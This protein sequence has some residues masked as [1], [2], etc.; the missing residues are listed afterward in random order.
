VKYRLCIHGFTFSESGKGEKPF[1]IKNYVDGQWVGG[2]QDTWKSNASGTYTL[3]NVTDY[4][5]HFR[6]ELFSRVEHTTKK[7]SDNSRLV[8]EV[9]TAGI[10]KLAVGDAETSYKTWD[11]VGE[12]TVLPPNP[13]VLPNLSPIHARAKRDLI[14]KAPY[15]FPN[16]YEKDKYVAANIDKE[17]EKFVE[18]EL[19]T[20]A[21]GN[22]TAPDGRNMLVCVKYKTFEIIGPKMMPDP[23]DPKYAGQTTTSSQ[24]PTYTLPSYTQQQPAWMGTKSISTVVQKKDG[25]LQPFSSNNL[26]SSMIKAGATQ[27]QATIVSNQIVNRIADKPTITTTQISGMVTQSLSKVNTTAAQNY[28]TF[29]NQRNTLRRKT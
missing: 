6:T 2:W 16:E 13:T 26:Y 23:S 20:E 12:L 24:K 21:L 9:L 14:A 22:M 5:N 4:N 15:P 10:Y 17:A 28:T 25:N 3:N 19:K 7:E 1:W 8:K 18:N 29:Q 27:P 11:K